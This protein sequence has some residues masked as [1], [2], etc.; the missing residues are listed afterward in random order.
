MEW[1]GTTYRWASDKKQTSFFTNYDASTDSSDHS[2]D[3]GDVGKTFS[4]IR[5]SVTAMGKLGIKTTRLRSAIS[6]VMVK[7][8][9]LS[10][11]NGK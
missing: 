10:S 11:G 3:V 2:K 6:R 9:R 8:K 5:L 1:N 4:K 7:I